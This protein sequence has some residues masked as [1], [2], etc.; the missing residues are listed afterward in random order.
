MS[1]LRWVTVVCSFSHSTLFSTTQGKY[2]DGPDTTEML[3][4]AQV[5]PSSSQNKIRLRVAR[6][7]Q[8]PQSAHPPRRIPRPDDPIPRKPP[9]HIVPKK[10]IQRL[11]SLNGIGESKDLK[12]VGSAGFLGNGPGPS[13][14][15]KVNRT[16][17]GEV[18]SDV[19]KMPKLPE[20]A[21]IQRTPPELVK[22]NGKR[23]DVFG[24]VREVERQGTKGK[25]KEDGQGTTVDENALEKANKNVS[26]RPCTNTLMMIFVAGDQEGDNRILGKDERSDRQMY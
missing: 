19:F 25:Q 7:D 22:S 13:K 10:S 2:E 8:R 21:Q 5:V 12:R 20:P 18:D 11:G 17:M 15:A 14:K 9:L 4:F 24:E 16:K 6:L 23:K 26:L 3:I 1:R